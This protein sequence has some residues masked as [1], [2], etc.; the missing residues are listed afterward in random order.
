MRA[1][2]LAREAYREYDQ[3]ITVLTQEHGKQVYIAKGVKKITSKNSGALEPCSLVDIHTI[4]GKESKYVTSVHLIEVFFVLRQDM[5]ALL[6]AQHI[7]Q[8]MCRVLAVGEKD[9]R[10]YALFFG[11]LSAVNNRSL[12]LVH[13]VEYFYISFL[14]VLG[15]SLQDIIAF[16]SAVSKGDTT[17]YY[18]SFADGRVYTKEVAPNQERDCVRVSGACIA[19]LQEASLG[20]SVKISVSVQQELREFLHAALEYYTEKPQ[21]NWSVIEYVVQNE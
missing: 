21:S 16:G 20:V 3:R 13:C 11:W 1:I 18:Y 17:W 4:Q 12:L 6:C 7:A 9:V 14:E 10:V 2:V 15:Y 8:T 19:A 5:H